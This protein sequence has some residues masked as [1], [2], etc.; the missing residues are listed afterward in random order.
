MEKETAAHSSVLAW[1]IPGTGEPGGLPSMGSHRVRLDWSDLAAVSWGPP[2]L[3][4][5][6]LRCQTFKAYKNQKTRWIHTLYSVDVPSVS[7]FWSFLADAP[8]LGGSSASGGGV[9]SVLLP[10]CPGT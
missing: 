8:A 2:F 10:A 7:W 5:R 4:A 6:P 1:R 9:C 3:S